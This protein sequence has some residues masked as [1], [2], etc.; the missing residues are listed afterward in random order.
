LGNKWKSF[1]CLKQECFENVGYDEN[2]NEILPP[3]TSLF[4][5]DDFANE[6]LPTSPWTLDPNNIT[7]PLAP[8]APSSVLSVDQTVPGN[9]VP[10]GVLSKKR[11]I[12]SIWILLQRELLMR[13]WSN[14][15]ILQ[16]LSTL[17]FLSTM[18]SLPQDSHDIMLVIARA[19]KDLTF[20]N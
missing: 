4:Q 2:G 10:E 19:C 15:I 14:L 16:L 12:Q 1:F 17:I 20:A 8:G 18:V 9:I 6:V 3:L 7:S 11:E 5:Q 13:A